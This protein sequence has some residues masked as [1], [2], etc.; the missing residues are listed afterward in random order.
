M[1]GGMMNLKRL[2][3]QGEAA[4]SRRRLMRSWGTVALLLGILL[5]GCGGRLPDLSNLST[6]LQLPTALEDMQE[7]NLTELEVSDLTANL[8]QYLAAYNMQYSV[9]PRRASSPLAIA[10]AYLRE[11]QPGPEPRVFQTTMLYDRNGT[12]LA[13]IVDEGYRTWVPLSRISPDLIHALL[14]TEDA[15]FYTNPGYD[16]RRV[17]GAM[18]QNAEAGEVIS[19]ASTVTMQ[20]ARQLFFT[21]DERYEQTL[22]RKVF[23]A[24]LAQDLTTTYTKDEILE[25]YLNLVHFGRTVYGI[26]AAANLYFN[27]SAASLTLAE[28]T[29]LAGIPQAPADYDP[30]VNFDAVKQRQGVVLSLMVRHGF[31]TQAQANAVF[32]SQLVLNPNIERPPLFAPHFVQ[33]VAS[34]VNRMQPGQDVRRSGMRIFTTLDLPMQTLA[35]QIVREQVQ[36]LRPV[37]DLSNAALVALKPGTAEILAMVGSADFYDNSIAGQVNVAV[38]NRQPGSA[39]KPI[40]YSLAMNDLQISPATII[41]DVEARYNLDPTEQYAPLNYDKSFHGPVTVRTALAN[42]YNV[43]AVKLLDA[44]GVERMLEGARAMGIRSLTRDTN[45]YGLSLTLGGGEVTLLD[46]TTAFHTIANGGRYQPPQSILYTTGAAGG[47]D[48]SGVVPA[49]VQVISPESAYLVT[50][51]LSDNQARL[52]AFGANSALRL[53]QPA[54]AKT[55]TTTDYRDNWTEGFTRYLVTGVWAGNSDGRPMRNVSGVTGAA[56]IWNAFMEAVLAD[57]Q[58]LAL[59]D[60]P[61]DPAAWAFVAPAGVV[62]QKIEC[63]SGITCAEEEVFDRHW[64]ELVGEDAALADS[65]VVANMNLLYVNRGRGNV[66]MGACSDDT[67]STRQLLRLPV[68]L[69][70]SLA[71]LETAQNSL[72]TALVADA[73]FTDTENSA[74]LPLDE[75][76]LKRIRDE[77]LEAL[78]WSARQGVPLYFGPCAQVETVVRRIYGDSVVSIDISQFRDEVASVDDVTDRGAREAGNVTVAASQEVTAKPSTSYGSAGVAHDSSCGGDYVLGS[79][80]NA[81]GQLIPAVAVIYRDDLGN[82]N[83]AA[84]V[85]GAY[86]FS[87]PAPGTARNI[88]ISLQDAAGNAVSGTIT[89]PHRQGGASDLGCHYVVWQGVN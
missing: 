71:Q 28:A 66:P 46:L 35:Q 72:S 87:I 41:W 3:R 69:T 32:A 16:A 82:Q 89:V 10:E 23:E 34:E 24:L 2:K 53:S 15:T 4:P 47:N 14:A 56:P 85:N 80:Y 20:L 77:Q 29:L 25:M 49:P 31:L 61:T 13:E 65:A 39:I 44:V 22:D 11:Y 7:I 30:L 50:N 59:L 68:G 40:L 18:M 17:V 43:P 1:T 55:G 33:Y 19:G 26:E 52:P 45:W 88:Y 9:M 84:A 5:S 57:P 83:Y 86:R 54:A 76:L 58:M 48:F 60:A 42:S 6:A 78:E 38:S 73:S 74:E 37:Y 75:E 21:Q 27:K 70:R 12:K 64:L 8:G 67:G 51:I 79:V 36:A 62:T 63:P 81:Q